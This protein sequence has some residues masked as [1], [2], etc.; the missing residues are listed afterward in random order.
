MKTKSDIERVRLNRSLADIDAVRFTHKFPGWEGHK[1]MT[2]SGVEAPLLQVF[3]GFE[4]VDAVHGIFGAN[5]GK[6]L[7][8]VKVAVYDG[9]GYAWIDNERG[10][11]RLMIN[12]QYLQKGRKIDIYLDVIHELTHI[13]QHMK[14]IDLWDERYRY[15]DRPTEIEAYGNAVT[16]ARRLGMPLKE[17]KRYLRVPYIPKENFE[18]LFRNL[19]LE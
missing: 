9:M 8:K 18:R 14:G 10:R 16:E 4:N 6:V 3:R 19:G 11:L 15:V 5:T 7:A 12:R 2:L 1:G 17:I 13:R